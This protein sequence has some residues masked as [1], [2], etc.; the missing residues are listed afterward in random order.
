MSHKYSKPGI[1]MVYEPRKGL[2]TNS[3]F[4]AHLWQGDFPLPSNLEN[5]L[6]ALSPDFTCSSPGMDSTR[7]ASKP[8]PRSNLRWCHIP[9]ASQPCVWDAANGG[10]CAL[11]GRKRLRRNGS[12]NSWSSPKK[13]ADP[14]SGV[15]ELLLPKFDMDGTRF[16]RFYF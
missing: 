16:H 14:P 8:F 2:K 13:D 6:R 3:H 12:R 1:E 5:A 9:H 11:H 10:P 7:I 15:F 4:R